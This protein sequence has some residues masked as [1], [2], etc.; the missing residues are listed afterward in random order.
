MGIEKVQ[1]PMRMGSL[2]LLVMFVLNPHAL[3][4]MEDGFPH[5]PPLAFN[6][7]KI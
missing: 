6:F 7:V 3:I 1:I 5:Q 4:T 2:T